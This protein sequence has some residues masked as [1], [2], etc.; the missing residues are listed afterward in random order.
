MFSEVYDQT[1]LLNHIEIFDIA[2][3]SKIVLGKLKRLKV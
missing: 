3:K 1:I 2:N